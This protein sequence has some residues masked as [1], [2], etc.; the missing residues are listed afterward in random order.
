VTTETK[1]SGQVQITMDGRTSL[2]LRGTTLLN[3]ARQMGIS[4]PTLCNYRG[5]SPYGACRVCLVEL[6]T[7]RGGQLVASCSYPAEDGLV[8]RTETETV[9][10]AR[11]TTLELLLAQAPESQEL[12]KFAAGLGVESTP[13]EPVAGG[14][15]IQCGLCGRICNEMMGRGAINLY[16]RG[17]AREVRT[18]YDEL[19]NQCQACGACA[20]V[21]PTGAIDLKMIT[22]WHLAPHI[23]GYDKFLTARPS[24]DLAHPQASPR[25][26]VID[27]DS[28]I[29][30]RTGECGLC[31]KVCQAGA[32]EYG[33]QDETVRLEVG[34]VVLTPGFEAFDATRRG[35]FG[36]GYASN[37][38]SNVQFE[39]LLSASGPTQGHVQRPSDRQAPK[40]LAFIQCVGSRDTGCDNDYCSSVCCMAATKEAILAKE[41]VSGLDITIFFLD[42]RAFGKDFDRYCDR[43]KNQLGVRY[44]R[45]F[46]SRTYEMPGS[47][48]LRLVYANA[49]MKQI[50]EE[51]DMVVLSLGLEPSATI[52][53]Q[54]ERMGV[55]L[56]RWGFAQTSELCPLDTSR[57]GIFV[58]GAFQEPKDIPD[59]VMQAS[60]AGARAMA[61]L[62]SARGTRVRTKTY[63][64]ER[65]ITDEPPRVGV[66][67]CHC[68]SNIAS[69]V[70]VE[71]VVESAR[72]FPHVALAE[73]NTYTC[74]DDTQKRIKEQIAAHN[75]NRVIVASCTPRTHEPIFRD[76]LRDAGLNPYLLEMANIRDQCSWVHASQPGR[77]T[78]KA[79][80]LVRMAVGRV[81]SAVPLKEDS[82]PV[83]NAALVIG[84]GIAGLTAALALADQGYPVHLVEKA[85]ELGGTIRQIH[86]TLDGGDVQAF[87]SQTIERARQHPKIHFHLKTQVDK[88]EGHM[89][90]FTSALRCGNEKS[91]V[92]H[93]VVVVAT[94][95]IEQ[96]PQS[97]GYG[98]HPKVITQLELSDQLGRGT[99]SLPEQA[100]IA[101]IQCVEQRTKERPYCSRVCC[102]TAVKNA[103]QL[104]ARYPQSRIVVLYRDMRTYGFREAA[105]KEARE[106]GVLF[107]RYEPEQPPQLDW[108]GPLHLTV[109]EPALGRELELHPDLVVLA[110]PMVPRA[111]RQEISD[112]L[113]VPLNADGFF[114]EAHMKLRPVDFAS[115]GLFLC[116]TAHAPKF[117]SEVISQANAVA[118]RAS[119]ILSKKK[120]PLSG[121]IAWVDPDKCISCATCVHVCPYMATQINEFNKAEV[122]GAVCMGCGSCT[123]ECPAK[124]ITLRH[125]TDSQILAA[126]N[127][128][129]APEATPV[130][131]ASE[132][133][134][135]VGVATPRWHVEQADAGPRRGEG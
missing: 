85:E 120:M 57:P 133:P 135:Q 82:V 53:Q 87:L 80:D 60:A 4:I 88:V 129:L 24:I 70:D 46:I 105:Y 103:L 74:A 83:N 13:F 21:C 58:G 43:A 63:P 55:V 131:W 34:A 33:Q 76:T 1:P 118:G 77:A 9:R 89:G 54:A 78:D 52:Q 66:F 5:L 100:T 20:F 121:Q 50:E 113:R 128:L 111:D 115:E 38:L 93:G 37:V 91:N 68:G 26:P 14:K 71:R 125:F 130:E 23:T 73:H 35:E 42:L 30:F 28:C 79:V 108:D 27:R 92:K 12:A 49:D 7:P 97:Y 96:K 3:A 45:S 123:S 22:A 6:E 59:T 8:A 124:A 72:G 98:R 119:S 122:Q 18:A 48:N 81:A 90:S 39:R 114:L 134:E 102:T 47:K 126:V 56:N 107:V 84:G 31:E 19:S 61:L 106:K 110:A 94:G 17:I 95:A 51:F 67:I 15:C 112:L 32:I 2:V 65:D 116:G 109:R 64:P 40:R 69:V 101:M 132:Y 44:V 62:A 11:Q 36:Y 127:G 41:H 99:L 104:K 29:H 86:G 117:I 75:L 25:V 16:G 10:V